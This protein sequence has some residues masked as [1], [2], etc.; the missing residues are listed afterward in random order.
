MHNSYYKQYE[1]LREIVKERLQN[2]L[3]TFADMLLKAKYEN[4]ISN[5]KVLTSSTG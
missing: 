3:E 2:G 1:A 4:V 5:A